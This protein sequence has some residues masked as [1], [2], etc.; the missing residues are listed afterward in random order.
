MTD[1]ARP[2]LS[3]GLE[4]RDQSGDAKGLA[5]ANLPAGTCSNTRRWSWVSSQRCCS[6]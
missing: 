3:S 6:S 4:A 5:G 1:V 2:E